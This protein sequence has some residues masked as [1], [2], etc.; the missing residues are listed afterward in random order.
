MHN[1]LNKLL[2]KYRAIPCI[3]KK[4]E[5]LTVILPNRFRKF[6]NLV[7]VMRANA[8][9]LR[10]GFF[11]SVFAM[12]C[13]TIL[14]FTPTLQDVVV[15]RTLSWENVTFRPYVPFVPCS[16][17]SLSHATKIHKLQL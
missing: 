17:S 5:F 7:P 10:A 9:E 4:A 15:V 16:T 8:A 13:S 2:V 6:I 3:T 1:P 14:T 11:S 12:V